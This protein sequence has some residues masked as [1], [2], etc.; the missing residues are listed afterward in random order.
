MNGENILRRHRTEALALLAVTVRD[1]R[2]PLT[3]RL[4]AARELLARSEA[5]RP[6]TVADLELMTAE[7]RQSLLHVLLTRYELEMPGRFKAM[8][9]EAYTEAMARMSGLRP[10]RYTRGVPPP[11]IAQPELRRSTPPS[12]INPSARCFPR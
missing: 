6:A 8:M 5:A 2:A 11:A 3:S 10:C 7:Q 4:A 1:E 9:V 12:L